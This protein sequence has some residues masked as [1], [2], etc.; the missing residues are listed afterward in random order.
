MEGRVPGTQESFL[1]DYLYVDIGRT[2]SLLAQLYEGL[3]DKRERVDER[4]AKW[5]AGLRGLLGIGT[6][7]TGRQTTTRDT[8]QRT[9][10]NL[11]FAMLE[12][13]AEA[14]GY[15]HDISDAASIKSEWDSGSLHSTLTEGQLIRIKAPTQVI[16]PHHFADVLLRM[17]SLMGTVSSEP[18]TDPAAASSGDPDQD[19]ALQ[20]MAIFG[21]LSASE[22]PHAPK[23]EM[24]QMAN[25]IKDIMYGPGIHVRSLPLGV[26]EP[27]YAITGILTDES[28]YVGDAEKAAILARFGAQ[29]REWVMVAQISRIGTQGSSINPLESEDWDNIVSTDG[30]DANG[31]PQQ[32]L[33]RSI[34]ERMMIALLEFLEGAG[35]SEGPKWPAISVVPLGVYRTVSPRYMEMAPGASI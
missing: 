28:E 7:E 22:S 9:L 20:M 5:T 25:A 6:L 26:D 11:H 1:R 8:E 3:P 17:E 12:D 16:N 32:S 30:T 18:A 15:L 14:A 31:E 21:G 19:A 29:A 13:L 33:D 2:R 24:T 10:G 23:S 34:L 27:D 35:M 4:Q